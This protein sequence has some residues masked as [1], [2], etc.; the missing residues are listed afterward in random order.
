MKR[1]LIVTAFMLIVCFF[2]NAKTPVKKET[3]NS[4]VCLTV[5]AENGSVK[6]NI[7]EDGTITCIIKLNDLIRVSSILLNGE[8]ITAELEKNKLNL[9]VLTKNS[10]LEISF[11]EPSPFAQPVYNTIAMY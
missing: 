2:T 10:T 3:K 1:Y 11:E 8:D 9:P 4:P 5:Q 7:N 6:Q